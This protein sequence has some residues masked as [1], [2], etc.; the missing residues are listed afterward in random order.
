[1]GPDRTEQRQSDKLEVVDLRGC[2]YDRLKC[3]F[4]V[5]LHSLVGLVARIRRITLSNH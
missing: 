3:G 1:V 2:P 5:D 4:A